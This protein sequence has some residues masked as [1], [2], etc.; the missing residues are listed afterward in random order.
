MLEICG[1]RCREASLQGILG[2]VHCGTFVAN[3]LALWFVQNVGLS[4]KPHSWY[5]YLSRSRNISVKIENDVGE[6][7]RYLG[8][9]SSAIIALAPFVFIG[10]FIRR[11][12]SCRP[13]RDTEGENLQ[14]RNNDT[15]AASRCWSIILTAMMLCVSFIFA[16]L[17]TMLFLFD[18]FPFG[19]YICTKFTSHPVAMLLS[20]KLPARYTILVDNMFI[21]VGFVLMYYVRS[22][23]AFAVGAVGMG[24][25]PCLP[26]L[27]II[28]SRC[29]RINGLVAA[30]FAGVNVALRFAREGIMTSEWF[31]Y[32]YI[33]KLVLY[34]ERICMWLSFISLVIL[35]CAVSI[36]Y[37]LRP[38]QQATQD[39]EREMITPGTC[40]R[41]H[42]TIPRL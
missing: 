40:S 7:L 25:G 5:M 41:R 20:M 13:H 12:P 11:G 17:E 8:L 35:L 37:R 21:I 3:G 1:S 42:R 9:I 34:N 33:R 26:R 16:L 29:T 18:R 28:T 24:L 39:G 15:A 6:K 38:P 30:L 10:L 36:L 23:F 2:M 19:F 14:G 27:M 4:M 22:A 31:P 32:L